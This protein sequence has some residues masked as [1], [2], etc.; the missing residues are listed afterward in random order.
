MKI[1]RLVHWLICK[2]WMQLLWKRPS[3]KTRQEY[4]VFCANNSLLMRLGLRFRSLLSRNL[5]FW[6]TLILKQRIVNCRWQL[7]YPWSPTKVG[8]STFLIHCTN[9]GTSCNAHRSTRNQKLNK[10]DTWLSIT[11]HHTN[12]ISLEKIEMYTKC[13]I[14]LRS[15]LGYRIRH[16]LS[17]AS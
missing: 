12:N 2:N 15:K 14:Y 16:W 5:I 17:I 1:F 9:L 13:N 3:Q 4:L 11:W 7:Q 10:F 6:V 8:N